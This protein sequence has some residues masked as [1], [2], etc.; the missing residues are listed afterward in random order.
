MG[1]PD[2]EDRTC[3]DKEPIT[4]REFDVAVVP[5]FKGSDCIDGFLQW[6][7]GVEEISD[8]IAIPEEK[9]VKIVASHLEDD[10]DPWWDQLRHSRKQ[11]EMV[12]RLLNPISW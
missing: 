10:V 6:I 9:M 3:A 2:E 12:T 4:F 8:S 7:V 11:Q 1:R 5:Y